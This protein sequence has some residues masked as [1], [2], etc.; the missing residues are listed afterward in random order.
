MAIY[1]KNT[2]KA[3]SKAENSLGR[4]G[5]TPFVLNKAVVDIEDGYSV[6]VNSLRKEALE[7]LL[8]IRSEVKPLNFTG[9]FSRHSALSGKQAQASG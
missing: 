5:G 4:T 9:K 3:F 1:R 7:K 8:A 6:K 2:E